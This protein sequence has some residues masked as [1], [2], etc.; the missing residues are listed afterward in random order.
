MEK[1][2]RNIYC[3]LLIFILVFSVVGCRG[4]FYYDKYSVWI[5]EDDDIKI[6]FTYR[7][8][9]IVISNNAYSFSFGYL[10]DG[11]FIEIY[12]EYTVGEGIGE[13]DVLIIAEAEEKKG[14]LYLTFTQDKLFDLEGKTVVLDPVTSED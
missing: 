4:N 5:S 1:I 8:F 13:D 14:R 3:V 11:S 6:D 12:D 7:E 2:T 10:Y 9:D